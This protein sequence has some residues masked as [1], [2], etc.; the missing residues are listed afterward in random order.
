MS[1]LRRPQ[2]PC[3]VHAWPWACGRG[4][5]CTTACARV[6]AGQPG[7]RVHMRVQVCSLVDMSTCRE[8]CAACGTTDMKGGRP[9]AHPPGN[10]CPT[11][12]QPFTPGRGEGSRGSRQGGGA[13]APPRPLPLR[14]ARRGPQVAD[15][16]CLPAP[17][18]AR[19][20]G[21]DSSGS[22]P[23]SA[24]STVAD[25]PIIPLRSDPRKTRGPEPS[26]RGARREAAGHPH[27]CWVP[28]FLQTCSLTPSRP[29]AQKPDPTLPDSGPPPWPRR[30]P[31]RIPVET[32]LACYGI[33]QHD[34]EPWQ[35]LTDVR[36][37]PL[38]AQDRLHFRTVAWSLPGHTGDSRQN[39][40]SVAPAASSPKS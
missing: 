31:R 19:P 27:P 5:M 14:A 38:A 17:L 32:F 34:T 4:W 24:P 3:Y 40:Q 9:G 30:R 15:G 6:H 29:G 11:R 35:F 20:L 8:T 21:G 1:P 7:T 26:P 22:A 33:S 36:L 18:L 10:A 39:A 12:P 2:R 23:P 37:C 13:R 16:G 28:A 25:A